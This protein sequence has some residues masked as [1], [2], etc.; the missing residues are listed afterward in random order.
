MC[1][2]DKVVIDQIFH[3]VPS[4]PHFQGA[5]LQNLHQMLVH[6]FHGTFW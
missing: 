3:I 4:E 6:S 2:K 1:I 5:F